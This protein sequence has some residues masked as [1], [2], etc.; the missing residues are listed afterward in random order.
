[1]ADGIYTAEAVVCPEDLELITMVIANKQSGTYEVKLY[2]LDDAKNQ[3]DEVVVKVIYNGMPAIST[4]QPQP[5]APTESTEQQ[6]PMEPTES[7]EQY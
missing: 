7:T 2:A 6:Q 4:E 3:S 5:E 1:M